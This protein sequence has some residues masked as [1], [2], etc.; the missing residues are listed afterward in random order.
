M[1]AV[2]T[3]HEPAAA[4][5]APPAGEPAAPPE[6]EPA[7][8]SPPGTAARLALPVYDKLLSAPLSRD[9]TDASTEGSPPGRPDEGTNPATPTRPASGCPAAAN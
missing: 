1:R 3:F 7:P 2:T 5:P 8:V 9:R 4:A 6:P